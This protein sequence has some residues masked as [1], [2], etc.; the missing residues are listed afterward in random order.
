MSDPTVGSP[1]DLQGYRGSRSALWKFDGGEGSSAAYQAHVASSTDSTIP[2]ILAR[3]GVLTGIGISR[4]FGWSRTHP[5]AHSDPPP[6]KT[7][8][9]EQIVG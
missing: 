1:W 9:R 4:R 7:G 3:A 5:T 6:T 8:E 2:G